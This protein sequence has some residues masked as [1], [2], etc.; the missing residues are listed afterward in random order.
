MRLYFVDMLINS[1]SG[2]RGTIGGS[3]GKGLTP[4]DIV[5]FAT[6]YGAW[7]LSQPKPNKLDKPLVVIGRDA[8]MS[9]RLVNDL[10]TSTL[11][12]LGV[13]VV[14]L[15]L[16]TTPTV[17]L[18]VPELEANGG[19]IITAS[20]NPKEWNALKLLDSRGEFLSASEGEKVIEL[21][22]SEIE[23]A[24]VDDLGVTSCDDSW[25]QWHVDH[26]LALDL[27]NASSIRGAGLKV[28]VDAVNSSGGIAI[29]MLL[30][31]LGVEVVKIHC[32]PT[33]DF[34]HNPE[35]LPKHLNDL[36]KVVVDSKCDLGISVDPDVD[37]LCFVNEDGTFFG[38]EYTLVAVADYVLSKTPGNTVSNLSSTRA[39]SVITE[40]HGGIYTASAVG[41]VNVVEAIRN[42]EAVIGGEGNGG[43]IYPT[44]HSGRDA[45]VGVGLFLSHLIE[46]G[47]K[48]SELRGTYPNFVIQKDKLSLPDSGVEE[49]LKKLV[50]NHPEAK[51]NTVDGVKFDLE[52]G[53]VHLRRSN[54]EPIIR[55]YAESN[56]KEAA[57]NLANRYKTELEELLTQFA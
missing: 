25:L 28:A 49:A 33:G 21:A 15:G 48:S 51:V 55:V 29:P 14:D 39:L 10:V 20:H 11:N 41:E 2:I 52:E 43:V 57:R 17:E 18:A 34:A 27:V 31:A 56:E 47:L 30:E 13:N 42:T 19:I 3:V 46:T 37:R 8:R 40:K 16:S 38:E 45:L 7:I 35:P 54:T 4:P 12:A 5:R 53:W 9:G 24:N 32:E 50:L 44:S 22:D 6:G 36:M 1:I 23:F 26:V